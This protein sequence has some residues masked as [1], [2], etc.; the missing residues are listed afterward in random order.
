MMKVIIIYFSLTGNTQKLAMKIYEFLKS[1]NFDVSLFKLERKEKCSFWKNCFY[2]IF[3]NIIKIEK[4]PD[5]ENY[6][7]IFIG[8]PVWAGKITP[9]VRSFIK[10]IELKDKKVFL[11]TTYGSG[12]LKDRAMKE[13]IKLVEEKGGK[14]I[15]KIELKGKNVESCT[16]Y[17]KEKIKEFLEN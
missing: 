10:N 9:Y 12:F 3:K 1:K 5:I 13:F 14:V 11:F 16:S 6:D 17:I 4:V 15:D 8:T 7:L 2:A